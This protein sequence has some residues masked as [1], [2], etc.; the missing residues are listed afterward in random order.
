[1]LFLGFFPYL[2]GLLCTL[3]LLA[4]PGPVWPVGGMR[5]VDGTCRQQNTVTTARSN[6]CLPAGAA[7]HAEILGTSR[8]TP[9]CQS[10]VRFALKLLLRA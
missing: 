6:M 1:M 2:L 7:A 8:A 5:G 9:A 10:G 4:L 3:S